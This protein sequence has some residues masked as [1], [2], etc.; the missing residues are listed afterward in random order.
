[1]NLPSALPNAVHRAAIDE[2]AGSLATSPALAEQQAR[3][4]LS[5]IPDDPRARLILA[6]ARRRQGD[7]QAA[8]AVLEPLAKAYPRAAHTQY[9]LGL[10]LSGLGQ[11]ARAIPALRQAVALKRDM[12]EAW[13]AL[14]DLLFR[15]GDAAGAETAYAEHRR[16]SIAD[17][18]LKEAAD[19]LFHGDLTRAETILRRRLNADPNDT[20]ALRMLA[21]IFL[22]QSRS[23]DAEILL[24]HC[25]ALDSGLDDARFSYAHALFQQQRAAQAIPQIERLLKT[26]PDDPAYRNLLA[27]CLAMVGEHQRV[28]ELYEGLLAEYGAQPKIWLN[29]GHALRTVGRQAEAVAAYKRCIALAPSLGEAYWSLANLKVASFTPDEE[30]DMARHVMR[31][32]LVADDRLHLHFAL[33]KA[34]EDRGDYAL[35]FEHYARGAKLRRAQIQYDADRTTRHVLRSKAIFTADFFAGRAA[36]GAS[37]D[38]P[39]FIV[40]LPR[41]GSTLVEQILASHSAVEGTMEL[42]DI[43]FIAK[44]LGW[45][46]SGDPTALYPESLAALDSA[47]RSALGRAY[48]DATRIH[49]KLGRPFFIDKM[50]NNFQHL[51]LIHLILPRSK[52]IDTRRHPLGSCFSAFKQ[53]FARGQNFSY[54]LGELG[55]YYR[56]YVDLLSHFDNILPNRIHRVSYEHLVENTEEEIRKLLQ[57]CNLPFEEG[58]LRFYENDRAVRT[59]SSEQVRRPISRDG[60][61]QWRNFDP[62]LGPLKDALGFASPQPTP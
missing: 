24:A 13:R 60:L 49:R 59:V 46:E 23:G 14:G 54:D 57:Y 20:V 40:G 62:W 22:C 51:G 26:R 11:N 7:F 31:P 45:S 61:N 4:V 8:L 25:L 32:D 47:Q 44:D 28:N 53:H 56:D 55:R 58:C 35:S 29:Y 34:L 50:P 5:R 12:A 6:S 30:A 36:A 10:A 27:A 1:V 52:I 9:E 18:R 16:A 42:P 43:G 19:A 38:E 15:A 3:A 41:S 2:A 33:G 39:I 21:E 17:P 48:L 37:S